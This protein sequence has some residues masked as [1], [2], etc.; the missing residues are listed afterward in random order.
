MTFAEILP[1]IIYI[2]LIIFLIVLIVI[3]IKLFPV[4]D[5]LEKLMDNVDEK[6]NTLNPVFKLID[7][8]SNSLTSGITNIIEHMIS[9]IK[10][11]FK[12]KEEDEDYE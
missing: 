6:I 4:I 8:T 5:K 11:L 3:G 1:I 9:L 7:V 2:L 10:K 12:K